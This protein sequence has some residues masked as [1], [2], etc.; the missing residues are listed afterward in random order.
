MSIANGITAHMNELGRTRTPNGIFAI[1][2]DEHNVHCMNEP[3]LDSWWNSLTPQ[4]KG[5]IFETETNQD[6]RGAESL[7]LHLVRIAEA[8]SE[9]RATGRMLSS[10]ASDLYPGS[11]A[12]DTSEA[13][14]CTSARN[15]DTGCVPHQVAGSALDAPAPR[16]SSRYRSAPQS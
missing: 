12:P 13:G 15:E 2:A 1:I 5:S 8:E 6:L 7:Q 4:I 14:T 10:S 9:I 3:M 16:T 11:S